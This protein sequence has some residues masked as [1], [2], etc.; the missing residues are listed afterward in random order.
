MDM[1]DAQRTTEIAAAGYAAGKAG[2]A[3]A[4]KHTAFVAGTG[5]TMAATL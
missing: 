1:S 5:L 3:A 4:V 2:G